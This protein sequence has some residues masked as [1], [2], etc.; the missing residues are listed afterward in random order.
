[1]NLHKKVQQKCHN[2]STNSDISMNS[3]SSR[4]NLS[5]K[6]YFWKIILKQKL[7]RTIS[8]FGNPI[9][10]ASEIRNAGRLRCSGYCLAVMGSTFV[11]CWEELTR[12]LL[13][14]HRLFMEP[15]IANLET[16]FNTFLYFNGIFQWNI[17][18]RLRKVPYHC[19]TWTVHL[20]NRGKTIFVI[21]CLIPDMHDRF[22]QYFLT[23]ANATVIYTRIC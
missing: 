8:K 1:M 9:F 11:P 2:S 4:L 5:V 18:F 16:H 15:F 10:K 13:Q 21:G 17:L 6:R 23:I 3:R 20:N 19:L 14:V 7:E 12:C 22:S